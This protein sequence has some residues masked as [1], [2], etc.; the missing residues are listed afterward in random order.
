MASERIAVSPHAYDLGASY[1]WE[2][3]VIGRLNINNVTDEAYISAGGPNS[4]YYGDGRTV[5][6][7]LTCKW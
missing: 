1:E 3:G 2:N 6:A 5:Q 7:S 4:S